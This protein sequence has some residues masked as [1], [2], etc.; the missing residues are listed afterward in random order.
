ML[1]RVTD[2]ESIRVVSTVSRP[3]NR[4]MYH[5][6]STISLGG[7]KRIRGRQGPEVIEDGIRVQLVLAEVAK[8]FGVDGYRQW[9]Q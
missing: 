9:Q 2:L 1:M 6:N 4:L 8:I 3:Y 5:D 7:W